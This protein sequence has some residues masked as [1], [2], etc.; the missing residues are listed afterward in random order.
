MQTDRN[1]IDDLYHALE[2][3]KLELS[4]WEEEFLESVEG[5]L[6]YGKSLSRKQREILDRMH[7]KIRPW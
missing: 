2:D 1:F 5:Q 6:D 3:S 4:Q 7:E